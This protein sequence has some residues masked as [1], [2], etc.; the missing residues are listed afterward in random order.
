MSN[1]AAMPALVMQPFAALPCRPVSWLWLNRLPCGKL[2]LFDGDPGRGKS[3]VT[4]DLCARITTG[5]L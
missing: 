1:P 5:R 3:L 2:A 4:L